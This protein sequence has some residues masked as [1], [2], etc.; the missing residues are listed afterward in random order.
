MQNGSLMKANRRNGPEVW[1]FR[2]R[3]RTSGK[4]VYRRIVL[5]SAQQFPTEIE[6]RAAAAGIVLEINVN[7][8]R[9][10]THALTISQLAEHYRHRELSP[11]NT[12]KSYSTKKG[13]ENYLKRWI[14]PKWGEFAI[15]K[16]KP[17]EVELWLRQLPL[18][19][20]SCAKIKNIMSVLFNH[21]RRYELFDDNPIQLVRQSAKRRRIPHILLVN[22]IRQLLS[23]VGPLPRILIF[24]DATTGLRQSELFGLR[25]R[26]LD[27][28]GGQMNVVRS[29]VQGVISSCKTETSMKPIPMGPYLA[30]MLKK[31]KDEAVYASPDDWVFASVRTRGKRP[32]WG[33][34]LM[35]KK[36]HPV[37]KKLG[38]NKRIGWHTFRHSYS[39]ILRS[40]GTDINVQQDL[41]RHSSARLTLDTYTQSVTT[42]KRE[43]Q[44]AVIRLLVTNEQSTLIA[45]ASHTE[46]RGLIGKSE[47]LEGKRCTFLHLWGKRHRFLTSLE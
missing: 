27:F 44:D 13:Y 41:L 33:Q 31:W 43:A 34:S 42:A 39:S 3:D 1:E 8:P 17:I 18:A 32:V 4:A 37:A 25:W 21:A 20:A 22:E 46:I 28:D 24:M 6:A 11:D 35:R 9:V 36:I 10:Q 29:V 40:L 7:D 45:P 47:E 12:W 16:I 19:R 5:G 30:D 15:C 14:V 2:W 38:I 26:D 23:A